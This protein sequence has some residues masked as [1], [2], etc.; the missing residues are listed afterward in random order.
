[1]KID[2][3][4]KVCLTLIAVSLS[5][6]AFKDIIAPQAHVADLYMIEDMLRY[7]FKELDSIK[8]NTFVIMDMCRKGG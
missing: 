3:Y 2:L 6:L 7:V 1:M 5:T 4:V 8:D